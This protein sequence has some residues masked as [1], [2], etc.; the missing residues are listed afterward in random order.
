MHSFGL[1]QKH[2][3]P[4]NS[5]KLSADFCLLSN[6]LL[7]LLSHSLELMKFI[8]PEKCS[9]QFDFQNK[10]MRIPSLVPHDGSVLMQ[11]EKKKLVKHLRMQKTNR[12]SKQLF[13]SDVVI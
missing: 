12:N 2:K 13:T 4:T 3:N 7:D 8:G 9:F 10:K 5:F 1:F 11:E 6:A